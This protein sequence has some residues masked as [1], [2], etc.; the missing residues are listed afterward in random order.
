MQFDEERDHV[1]VEQ[2]LRVIFLEPEHPSPVSFKK[3]IAKV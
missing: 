2:I 3:I 1:A